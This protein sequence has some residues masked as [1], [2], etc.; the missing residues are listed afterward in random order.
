MWKS[1]DE[2]KNLAADWVKLPFNRIN[3]KEM[4]NKTDFYVRIVNR[5]EKNLPDNKVIG[6][7]KKIVWELKDTIPVVVALRSPYLTQDHWNEIKHV[8]K[9]DFKLEDDSFTLQKLIG[10]NVG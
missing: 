4:A 8:V 10:M 5:C 3:A 2:F 1:I 9:G 6:F 7:L